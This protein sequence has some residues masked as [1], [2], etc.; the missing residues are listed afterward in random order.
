[1]LV[2][3]LLRNLFIYDISMSAVEKTKKKTNPLRVSGSSA[4]MSVHWLRCKK[5]EF[6]LPAEF[7]TGEFKIGIVIL[8]IHT[9]TI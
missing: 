8:P 6:T 4:S 5:A 7:V 3:K 2:P 1:M 9:P